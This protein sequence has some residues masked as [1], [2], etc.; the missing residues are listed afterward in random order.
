MEIFEKASRMKLRF[1]TNK[2]ERASLIFSSIGTQTIFKIK[3]VLMHCSHHFKFLSPIFY[4]TLLFQSNNSLLRGMAKLRFFLNYFNN[5][6]I[7]YS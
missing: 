7:S 1:E 6:K 5:L 3:T 2:Q 4:F